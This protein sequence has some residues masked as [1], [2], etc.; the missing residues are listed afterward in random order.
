MSTPPTP[1]TGKPKTQEMG[2]KIYQDSPA[3][4]TATAKSDE[5]GN[6][7]VDE[8]S[9]EVGNSKVDEVSERIATEQSVGAK[10]SLLQSKLLL[11]KS[12][13]YNVCHKA[14][15]IVSEVARVERIETDME[16]NF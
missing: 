4:A 1:S 12:A 14:S 8:V 2:I 7:K 16:P 15:E 9:D 6:S 11:Y 3:T 13:F 5:V 10:I